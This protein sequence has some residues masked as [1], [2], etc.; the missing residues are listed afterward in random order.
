MWFSL[1][2]RFV[3]AE[4]S[5]CWW[6]R[7]DLGGTPSG[8]CRSGRGGR[9]PLRTNPHR[10]HPRSLPRWPEW[11]PLLSQWPPP[12]WPCCGE[13]Q[14]LSFGL[15]QRVPEFTDSRRWFEAPQ[16]V[17]IGHAMCDD[18][19]LQRHH[20]LV[21]GQCLRDSWMNSEEA[22]WE[23]TSHIINL[24]WIIMCTDVMRMYCIFTI[25]AQLTLISC[26]SS[27]QD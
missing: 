12:P 3:W 14:S 17:W 19:A 11:L 26:D 23:K 25:F 10:L 9:A 18:G 21:V 2:W 13:L 4:V 5:L 6:R 22:V 1:N 7:A 24:W 16:V 15:K 8:S 20:R 27:F